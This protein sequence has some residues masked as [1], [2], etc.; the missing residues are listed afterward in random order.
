VS[1]QCD[2]MPNPRSSAVRLIGILLSDWVRRAAVGLNILQLPFEHEGVFVF[3]EPDIVRHHNPRVPV[4]V[5]NDG[6][7][8]V[9]SGAILDE[10]DRMVGPDRRLTPSDGPLRRR[11]LP[12]A[13]MALGRA[14]K[15]QRAFYENRVRPAE[16]VRTSWIEHNEVRRNSSV[17]SC[18]GRRT[19]CH[20][21]ARPTGVTRKRKRQEGRLHV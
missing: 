20:R 16:K 15:A 14:D 10:I 19:L 3:G 11:V 5:L 18:H 21:I 17:G 12:T 2:T 7:N 13:A 4:L 6:T 1:R 9:E 8:L